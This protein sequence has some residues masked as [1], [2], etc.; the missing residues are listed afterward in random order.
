MDL[1][2]INMGSSFFRFFDRYC[3]HRIQFGHG[4]A[5]LSNVK[6]KGENVLMHG[7]GKIIS[8]DQLYIGDHVRFGTNCHL[9]CTGG[10]RIGTN[11]QISRNVV[12]YSS[13]HNYLGGAIPYD[14]KFVKREVTIGRSVWIGMG[15]LILPGVDIGDGAVIGM[16]TVVSKDVPPMAIVVGAAQR[17]INQ[18]SVADFDDLDAKQMWFG[19][20]FPKD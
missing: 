10:V 3:L 17:T 6:N 15:V 2:F 13:N 14:N 8:P 19:K 9:N 11:T 12:I 16:G 20:L 4:R 5:C 18:R 7:Y 1:V